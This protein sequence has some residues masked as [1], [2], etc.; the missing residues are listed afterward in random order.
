[1]YATFRK[2]VWR[3]S[4]LAMKNSLLS[5]YDLSTSAAEEELFV[6]SWLSDGPEYVEFSGY[7]RNEGRKRITDAADLIDDAVQALDKCDSAEASRVY[8]ETLKRVVLLSNLARV[9]EDSVKT[10]YTREK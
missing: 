6:Q 5:T 10:T 2:Q 3:D 4:L 1:M 7:K 9:L 8:L